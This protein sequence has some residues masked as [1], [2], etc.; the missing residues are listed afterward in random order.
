MSTPSAF[1]LP[2]LTPVDILRM[3]LSDS[4]PLVAAAKLEDL[5]TLERALGRLIDVRA[6]VSI[7]DV[8][9]LARVPEWVRLLQSCAHTLV[10]DL[11]EAR[12]RERS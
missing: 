8:P 11:I 9:D 10:Q 7:R 6:E 3:L 4:L 2:T 12:K 1:R 5:E